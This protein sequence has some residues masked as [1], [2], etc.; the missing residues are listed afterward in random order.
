MSPQPAP[1]TEPLPDPACVSHE[2]DASLSL[3]PRPG[4]PFLVPSCSQAWLSPSPSHALAAS[5]GSTYILN[6]LTANYDSE[7]VLSLCATK[8]RLLKDPQP[9]SFSLL[10]LYDPRKALWMPA[11]S[12][13]LHTVQLLGFKNRVDHS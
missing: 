9:S 1:L 6:N 13:S 12:P 4:G 10:P 2:T 5:Q 8:L 7:K 11:L 3:H